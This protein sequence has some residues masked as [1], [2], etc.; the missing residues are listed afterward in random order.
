MRR[1]SQRLPAVVQTKKFEHCTF[2]FIILVGKKGKESK[3][4]GFVLLVALRRLS[5][6]HRAYFVQLAYAVFFFFISLLFL[7]VS[8]LLSL[9]R[10]MDVLVE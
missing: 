10:S 1:F 2:F 4:L 7:W 3:V 5:M 8:S 9:M 6:C